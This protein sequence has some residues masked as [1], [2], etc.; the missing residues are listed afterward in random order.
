M[1]IIFLVVSKRMHKNS[2]NLKFS[3]LLQKKK[4]EYLNLMQMLSQKH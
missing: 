3:L 4:K 1:K 2:T